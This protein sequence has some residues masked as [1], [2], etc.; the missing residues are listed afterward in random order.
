MLTFTVKLDELDHDGLY[1]ARLLENDRYPTIAEGSVRMDKFS[2]VALRSVIS[3][4]ERYRLFCGDGRPRTEPLTPREEK[5]LAATVAVY[6][7]ADRST[8]EF[9]PII[10]LYKHGS[11]CLGCLMLGGTSWWARPSIKHDPHPERLYAGTPAE[12]IN[13]LGRYLRWWIA[14][15]KFEPIGVAERDPVTERVLEALFG[16]RRRGTAVGR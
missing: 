10:E 9:A 16:S 4:S 11:Y 8:Y 3:Y 14:A 12:Q 15:G 1:L 5:H 7:E 6:G 13:K 2:R